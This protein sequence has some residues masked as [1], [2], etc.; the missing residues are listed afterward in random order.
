MVGKSNPRVSWNQLSA[1]IPRSQRYCIKLCK[2]SLVSKNSFRSIIK[3][4]LM[5]NF[6]K[7]SSL[8][9]FSKKSYFSKLRIL[10]EVWYTVFV[11]EKFKSIIYFPKIWSL[12]F[13]ANHQNLQHQKVLILTIL[14]LLGLHLTQINKLLWQKELKRKYITSLESRYITKIYSRLWENIIQ[15]L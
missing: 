1:R 15:L 7:V 4:G 5:V 3:K 12:V 2:K 8:I 13:L 6:S 10:H 9:F 14:V 11:V